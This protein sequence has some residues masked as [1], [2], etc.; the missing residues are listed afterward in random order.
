MRN[1][2]KW[3]DENIA[4]F[5]LRGS[6]RRRVIGRRI[7]F[8]YLGEGSLSPRDI[9]FDYLI[10]DKAH[11]IWNLQDVVVSSVMT[12]VE[13]EVHN[14]HACTTPRTPGKFRMLGS[15]GNVP[16]ELMIMPLHEDA[17]LLQWP[18]EF[19]YFLKT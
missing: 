1:K 9:E 18:L 13:C 14:F 19:I 16:K 3:R 5:G 7:L 8:Y 11:T 12:T 17:S 2:A 6:I 4:P 15:F 10:G